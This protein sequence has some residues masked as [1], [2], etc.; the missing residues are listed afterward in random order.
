MKGSAVSL[1]GYETNLPAGYTF[2]E[3]STVKQCS[4]FFVPVGV[5]PDSGIIPPTPQNFTQLWLN[6]PSGPGCLAFGLSGNYEPPP[7]TSA[8]SYD[9]IAPR[10]SETTTIGA[11]RASTYQAPNSPTLALYVQIPTAGGGEHDLIVAAEGM[12]QTDLIA[13]LEKA[14]PT[15]PVPT[16]PS[17]GPSTSTTTTSTT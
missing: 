13:M 11:Y 17:G 3:A 5:M 15:A 4:N 1:A 14:L 16:E 12:S 8:D 10:G 6:A 7:G 2:A 9:P